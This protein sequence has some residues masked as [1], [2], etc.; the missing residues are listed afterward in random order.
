[1]G[2]STSHGG[3]GDGPGLLP[4]WA[5]LPAGPGPDGEPPNEDAPEGAE[6][7]GNVLPVPASP[8]PRNWQN[9]KTQLTRWAGD[10]GRGSLG[11]A[12]RSYV[13]GHGGAARAARS[14]SSGRSAT[15]ALGGF[16]ADVGRRGLG[17]ALRDV[18]LSR[19]VGQDAATVLAGI[20]DRLAPV[21]D[22]Q[23]S[24]CARRAVNDVFAG[25]YEQ[26]IE[27]GGDL[28]VL[29]GLDAEAIAATVEQSVSAYIY[30][31]WLAELGLSIEKGAISE[32]KAIDLEYQ[33]KQYVTDCVALAFED[34]DL[35]RCDWSSPDIQAT[36]SGIYEQAYRILEVSE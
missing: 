20:A 17:P 4:D 35:L 36:I 16:L 32:A 18:G 2:T 11:A 24:A 30:Y 9:A 31:R 22:T 26:I 15:I 27:A 33:M 8:P 34:V 25:L 29:E 12:A 14:S 1:M 21:G 19:L 10:G 13:G 6:E 3:P 23:E 5:E 7:N 28:A